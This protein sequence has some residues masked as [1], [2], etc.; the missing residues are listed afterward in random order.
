MYV[1]GDQQFMPGGSVLITS[2]ASPAG[3][4]AGEHALGLDKQGL[5]DKGPKAAELV[6]V[7]SAKMNDGFTPIGR[8]DAM[9]RTA[10]GPL[11]T[12]LE[13]NPGDALY[14][15]DERVWFGEHY[16][17]TSVEVLSNKHINEYLRAD[18]SKP[19][20][21]A[22]KGKLFVTFSGGAGLR[23]GAPIDQPVKEAEP[24]LEF[25]VFDQVVFNTGR[26]RGGRGSHKDDAVKEPGSAMELVWSFKDSLTAIRWEDSYDF[27][28]GLQTPD[29]RLRILGAAG[30]N[31]PVY[32]GEAGA[33]NFR[34]AYHESLP[35]QAR[36]AWEGVTLAGVTIAIANGYWDGA[37]NPNLNT[38]TLGDLTKM[39]GGPAAKAVHAMRHMRVR[40]LTSK[41]EATLAS[42][43]WSCYFKRTVPTSSI[44]STKWRQ[45]GEF[46][47]EVQRFPMLVHEI[48][49]H[50]ALQ[51]WW[52]KRAR[53]HMDESGGPPFV[54]SAL[55]NALL[56][57]ADHIKDPNSRTKIK[58]E[59]P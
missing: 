26:N 20:T 49:D 19:L 58:I 10:D 30:I 15:T 2:A 5:L 16:R 46:A 9:A 59:G 50:R 39:L 57:Y 52:E 23:P 55:D 41:A 13:T 53:P 22:D 25:G 42:A 31:N 40:P 11:R 4:Q 7:G 28:V 56:R 44:A 12:R 54:E 8:L 34:E 38:A 14:P 3:I 29:K 17:V 6:M 27:P 51:D 33:N 1:A 32:K 37:Y 21:R 45:G 43:F 36:V 47:E 35:W 48:N 18:G 24:K